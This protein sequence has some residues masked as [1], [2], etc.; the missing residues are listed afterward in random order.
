MTGYLVILATSGPMGAPFGHDKL[1]EPIQLVGAATRRSRQLVATS[2]GEDRLVARSEGINFLQFRNEHLVLVH[3][4]D[5]HNLSLDCG[6]RP[7]HASF[8]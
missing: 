8:C 1:K 6:C 4:I 7:L 3:G 2:S 5:E